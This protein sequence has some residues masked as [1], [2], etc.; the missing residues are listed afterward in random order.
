MEDWIIGKIERTELIGP[1]ENDEG[2]M[3]Q[4]SHVTYLIKTVFKNNFKHNIILFTSHF[5]SFPL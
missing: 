3:K 4:T 5:Y 2:D 1:N